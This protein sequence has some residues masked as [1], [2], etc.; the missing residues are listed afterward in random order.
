[1][2]C[3]ESNSASKLVVLF[4]SDRSF[5]VRIYACK[6]KRKEGGREGGRE[7][8]GKGGREGGRKIGREKEWR[9]RERKRRERGGG[10]E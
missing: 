10:S 2:A 9:K 5:L 8:V 6:R 3:L 7:G 1:M 4:I